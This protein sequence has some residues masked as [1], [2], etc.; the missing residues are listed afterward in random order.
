VFSQSS[1]GEKATVL[2]GIELATKDH[3]NRHGSEINPRKCDAQESVPILEEERPNNHQGKCDPP[4]P[5]S[6]ETG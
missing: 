5:F 6:D 3:D 2:R 1:G 4:H